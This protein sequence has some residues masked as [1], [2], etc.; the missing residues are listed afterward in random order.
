MDDK[1]VEMFKE[2]EEIVKEMA[3]SDF[4][5]MNE[6]IDYYDFAQRLNRKEINIVDILFS[7]YKEACEKARDEW[8]SSK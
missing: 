1:Y 2:I 5:D 3:K 6:C 8:K 4:Y 7:L